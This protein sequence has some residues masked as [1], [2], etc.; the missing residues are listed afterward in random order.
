MS[1]PITTGG[2]PTAVLLAVPVIA[3]ALT[4]YIV[5]GLRPCTVNSASSCV[6]GGLAV[7][8]SDG[9]IRATKTM[10]TLLRLLF[11]KAAAKYLPVPPT[12]HDTHTQ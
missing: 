2:P 9:C 1:E 6:M 3:Y 11:V 4:R 5:A 7:G 12:R 8:A 10:D